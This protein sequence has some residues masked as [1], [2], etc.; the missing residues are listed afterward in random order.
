MLPRLVVTT[1]LLL[2]CLS[3]CAPLSPLHRA[4]F[5]R[6]CMGVPTRVVLYAQTP[7]IAR[8]AAAAAFDRIGRLDQVM[9]D[10][11]PDSELMR[12]CAAPAGTAVPLSDDL[13][14]AL[15]VSEQL[16]QASDGAFDITIGPAVALWRQ[17]RKSGQLPTDEQLAAARALVGP[18]L[19]TLDPSA[20]PPTA[21][22]AKPGMKL[23]LGG[24]GKGFAAQAAV[25]LLRARGHPRCLVALAG[26][27][28]AG[29]SPPDAA[30]WRIAL[31]LPEGGGR[32]GGAGSLLLANAAISTSGDTEQ[33]V[34][35]GGKR[36]A[37]ILDPRTGLGVT[38]CRTAT[39][40]APRGEWADPLATIACILPPEQ[41][42]L[43]LKHFPRARLVK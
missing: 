23:D 38:E 5:T 31:S 30:G 13:F 4:E 3:G 43:V 21:T 19:L 22:L 27:I 29:D 11:R 24:I 28:A 40:I 42:A 18:H 6:L 7:E 34:E 26:D 41:F 16:T 39:V 2:A 14:R 35:I 9:S 37:H 33:F 20:H 36:Y 12:L 17:A 32:G 10:Y 1:I 25:D 8:D 15:R